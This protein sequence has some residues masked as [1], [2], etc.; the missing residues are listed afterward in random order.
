L[1]V[2][3]RQVGVL[4]HI[5]INQVEMA[6]KIA[7]IYKGGSKKRAD[8]PIEL[9]LSVTVIQIKPMPEIYGTI[10]IERF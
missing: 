6:A 8:T 5:L 2:F 10:Q 1:K 3:P 7:K 4:G 9:V